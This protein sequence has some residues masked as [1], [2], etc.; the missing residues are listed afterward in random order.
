MAKDVTA[1]KYRIKE[2]RVRLA[3][4]SHLYSDRQMDTPDAAVEVM[5]KEL[6]QYDREVL[7]VVNLN[8]H[9]NP[10]NFNIVSVG[11]L[12]S[13]IASIPNLLVSGILSNSSSFLV[14]HNHPSGDLTPSA[15]D[16]AMTRRVVEAGNLIGIPCVDHIIVAGGNSGRILSMRES[17][18]I[19]FNQKSPGL[20]AAD[21]RV[22]ESR[23]EYQMDKMNGTENRAEIEELSIKFGK[24]LAEPF[25][26]R[27][28]TEYMRIMI[29]NRDRTDTT[30]WA[31][32]VLKASQVHENKFGKGLWVKLPAGAHITVTKPVAVGVENGKTVWNNE[33]KSV[34]VPELKSMVEFYKT[35]GRD[36]VM[37]QLGDMKKT[38]EKQELKVKP[39]KKATEISK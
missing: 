23:E 15:E 33:K 36:S 24:G 27:D 8:S 9:L 2:V 26:A 13:T 25:T 5:K 4:G 11:D 12:T 31:S 21:A 18:T 32:F 14:L 16:I 34:S 20:S 19:N 38:A 28:G 3:E 39:R 22:G 1:K 17:G 29:P 35:K 30:P 10:I 7:V 6:S 37:G